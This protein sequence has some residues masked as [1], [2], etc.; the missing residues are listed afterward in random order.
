MGAIELYECLSVSVKIPH[1]E[2]LKVV[3]GDLLGKYGASVE[4][5]DKKYSDAFEVVLK[6]YLTEDEFIEHTKVE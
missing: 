3:I 1:G 2:V 6:F 4:R 5:K